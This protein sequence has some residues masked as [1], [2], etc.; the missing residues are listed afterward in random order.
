MTNEE[1]IE[2]LRGDISLLIS[3]IYGEAIDLA[4]K[5]LETPPNNDWEEYSSR[6]WKSAYERG[7]NEGYAK[8]YEEG[9]ELG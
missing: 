9:V 6:L 3:P 8:G 4:I 7:Y 5:A 2:I 1:A